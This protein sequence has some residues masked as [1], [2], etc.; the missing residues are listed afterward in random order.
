MSSY[1]DE[2]AVM[3]VDEIDLNDATRHTTDN[4]YAKVYSN[5]AT[6]AR[7]NHAVMSEKKPNQKEKNRVEGDRVRQLI[8]KNIPVSQTEDFVCKALEHY[9]KLR[10]VCRRDN[11]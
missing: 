6:L 10:N 7:S 2:I 8:P 9:N 11:R 5:E 4:P 3:M 1:L